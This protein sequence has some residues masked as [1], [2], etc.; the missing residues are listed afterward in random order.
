MAPI[1]DHIRRKLRKIIGG[2]FD[3]FTKFSEHFQVFNSYHSLGKRILKFRKSIDAR[4][5]RLFLP[6]IELFPNVSHSRTDYKRVTV[7]EVL[8]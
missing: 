4:I 1:V 7:A 3:S 6:E 2:R 8:V 5:I